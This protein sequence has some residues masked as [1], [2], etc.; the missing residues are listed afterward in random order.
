MTSIRSGGRELAAD[1]Y[2]PPAPSAVGVLFL[3]G[4]ESD[5]R[6][7]ASRARA[8]VERL[9]MTCLAFDLTGHGESPGSV[10]TATAEEHR[11]DIL[12]AYDELAGHVDRIGVCGA[13]YGGYL[14]CVLLGERPVERLMLRAPALHVGEHLRRLVDEDL[15]LGNLAGYDGPVLVLESEHDEL[16]PADSIEAYLRA[17]RHGTHRV[18]AG[19][20]HALSDP[21]WNAAFIDEI[22]DW[23]SGM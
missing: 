20:T 21:A 7:Y 17:A 1:L 16:I 15:V 4:Y 5:R 2:V 14:S 19:A 13:S 11:Q 22:V 9:G 3:H 6:G 23:F 18:L 10:D 8:V 12:A